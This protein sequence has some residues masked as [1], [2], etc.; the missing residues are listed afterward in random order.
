MKAAT[1]FLTAV[2]TLAMT[3]FAM[4]NDDPAKGHGEGKPDESKPA[5][6]PKCPVMDEPV[7]F[8][9]STMTKDGPVYFCCEMCINKYKKDPEKYAEK[10]ATQRKVLATRDRVQVACPISGESI[11]TK[12]F[13]GEGKDRVYF[14]CKDC[15]KKYTENP[16][17]YAEKLATSYTYQTR[18]PVM[19]GKIDPTVSAKLPT[20][21]RIYY[22]CRGCDK[23][24]L[25][26]PGK[27]AKK[28]AE[29]GIVIDVEKIEKASKEKSKS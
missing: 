15:I 8:L 28:L 29:Q 10:V 17:K 2:L 25:E 6:L 13:T 24:V 20:G 12:V 11:D 16:A 27:Y 22:C 9:I 14:C 1:L 4:S 7:N 3:P 5:P 18:C 26:N 19:G 23:K 21:E